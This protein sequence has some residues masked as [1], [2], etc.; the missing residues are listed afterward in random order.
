MPL[1]IKGFPFESSLEKEALAF[2]EENT[3]AIAIPKNN[4]L[5]YQGDVCD[6]VLLLTKG[7]VR[8]YIQ[9]EGV[10]SIDLYTLKGGEQCIVNTA[11]SISNTNAIASAQTVSDIEG[12]LLDSESI[13]KLSALSPV[14]QSYIFSLYTI[15]MADLA[16]LINDIKFKK[17]DTRLLEWLYKHEEKNI[18]I[19]H[20]E[21]ANSLGSS[22]VVISR[23]LKELERKEKVILYRGSIEVL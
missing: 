21:I 22:R 1:D 14:Y 11:S 8:L 13:K 3:K 6:S 16:K 10:E 9:D 12:Y 2:L 7:E 23:T 20:E 5:F 19:T 18:K 17:L 15:R 4:I